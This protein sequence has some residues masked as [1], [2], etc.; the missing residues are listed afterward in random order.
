MD[1]DYAVADRMSDYCVSFTSKGNPD[2]KGL[3]PWPAISPSNSLIL[4]SGD[5]WGTEPVADEKRIDFMKEWFS[6][7]LEY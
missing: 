1:E 5:G 4:Q 6:K 3:P 7:C 2:G